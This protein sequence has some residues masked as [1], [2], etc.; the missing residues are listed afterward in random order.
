MLPALAVPTVTL[1]LPVRSMKATVGFALKLLPVIVTGVPPPTSPEGGLIDVTVG[2]GG[3]L[4]GTLKMQARS[5]GD[6]A[7]EVLAHRAV[8]KNQR[9]TADQVAVAHE[10]ALDV[11]DSLHRLG[12]RAGLR[13]HVA[14]AAVA[15]VRRRAVAVRVRRAEVVAHLVAE[16]QSVAR[17]II[18][19]E[20]LVEAVADRSRCRGLQSR[21]RPTLLHPP[22]SRRKS[23]QVFVSP[24]RSARSSSSRTHSTW[25]R[26]RCPIR[27]CTDPAPTRDGESCTPAGDAGTRPSRR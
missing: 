18:A 26:P 4:A 10:R 16:D 7:V 11:G 3:R 1:T 24:R 2:P 22:A 5:A 14:L 23:R 17:H 15:V 25:S 6:A 19:Q 12:H 9:R 13:P 21:R 20:E 8:M 27:R